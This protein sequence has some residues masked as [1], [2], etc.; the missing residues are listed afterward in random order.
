MRL[1]HDDRPLAEVLVERDQTP[2]VVVSL[3]RRISMARL[4]VFWFGFSFVV[5]PHP[6]NLDDSPL[7]QNLVDETVLDVDS[8]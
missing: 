1:S 5:C 2:L 4:W 8:S 7:F 3:P 6:E